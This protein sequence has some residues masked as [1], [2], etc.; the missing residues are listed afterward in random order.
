MSIEN[1]PPAVPKRRR[2]LKPEIAARRLQQ[3]RIQEI[4]QLYRRPVDELS[5]DEL[6]RM[7]AVFFLG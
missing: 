2:R 7:K 1:V 4:E 5:P 6:D 3:R